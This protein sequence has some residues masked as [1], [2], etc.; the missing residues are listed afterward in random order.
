LKQFLERQFESPSDLNEHFAILSFKVW[1]LIK[2]WYLPSQEIKLIQLKT[3]ETP[4]LPKKSVG[5]AKTEVE[6]KRKIERQVTDTP[7]TPSLSN[8]Y[9]S[10]PNN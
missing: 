5:F 6:P 9:F 3:Q 1:N 7:I 8:D 10:N 2:Q 4:I